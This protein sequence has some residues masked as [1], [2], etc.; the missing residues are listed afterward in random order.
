MTP[1]GIAMLISSGLLLLVGFK[2]GEERAKGE[3]EIE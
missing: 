3:E 2:L 1:E